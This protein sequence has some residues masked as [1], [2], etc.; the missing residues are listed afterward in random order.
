MTRFAYQLA[1]VTLCGLLLA[2]ASVVPA[3]EVD[4]KKLPLPVPRKVDFEKDIYPL[5]KES[6][7]SCH[8]PEKQKGK[9]RL[10]TKEGAF[11][12]G[13]DG[14]HIIPGHSEKSPL[15]HMVAGLIE[16]GLMPP[17]D[18][19]G[20]SQP[21]TKE[22]IG[23]LRAWIDQG[24]SWPD[25]PIKEFVKELTFAKDIQPILQAACAECHGAA[26][27]QGGFRADSREAVL[28]GGKNYGAAVLA[29]NGPKSP[30][31]LIAAGKD[32]DIAVPEKHKLGDQQVE[33]LKKWIE[34]GAK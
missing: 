19:K 25:G 1:A 10:D 24:A 18:D 2:L 34:Q 9:Y 32:E 3:A 33:L 21:L 4:V 26:Q 8:G 20:K 31:L 27:A 17:P 6:C 23:L 28:K 29:G 5:L 22:Q 14:P 30:L 16:E 7:F 12:K 15:I 11:K 13:T